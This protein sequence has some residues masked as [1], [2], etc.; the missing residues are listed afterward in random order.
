MTRTCL[1]F[2]AL[3]LVTFGCEA[4][5]VPQ[6]EATPNVS[7]PV[8]DGTSRDPYRDKGAPS[9]SPVCDPVQE[10]ARALADEHAR[11]SNDE[12]CTIE[13]IKD[14]ACLSAFR[15]PRAIRAGDLATL[16]AK[17]AALSKRAT[18]SC[19]GC[20]LAKCRGPE[21]L[22]AY[23]DPATS[24]CTSR[25]EPPAGPELDDAAVDPVAPDASTAPRDA[26]A[27]RADAGRASKDASA[28]KQDGGAASGDP[29]ACEQASDCVVKD[30]GNCCGYYPRC[31]NVNATFKRPDCSGGQAGVCGF[32]VIESCGCESNKCVS[33]Q[34][35][36]QI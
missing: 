18:E 25:Y 27:V 33:R 28:T 9:S 36:L 19:E 7:S 1:L 30:V 22:Q 34:A 11:C 35:G 29:F 31:A 16:R 20:S 15:C 13:W 14:T 8:E 12:D 24:R 23:C 10:E 5:Q 2:A 3:A 26:S 4:D 17:A 32:P 21:K 6:P